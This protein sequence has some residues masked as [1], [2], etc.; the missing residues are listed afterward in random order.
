MP[1]EAEV[2]V[3]NKAITVFRRIDLEHGNQLTSALEV[4]QHTGVYGR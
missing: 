2:S 3:V 4:A 1:R